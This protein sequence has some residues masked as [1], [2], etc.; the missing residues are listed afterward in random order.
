MLLQVLWDIGLLKGLAQHL[1]VSGASLSDICHCPHS[2]GG[3]LGDPLYPSQAG[4]LL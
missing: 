3:T 1:A 2:P 4:F